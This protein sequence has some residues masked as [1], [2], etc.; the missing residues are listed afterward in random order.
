LRRFLWVACGYTVLH[1]ALVSVDLLDPVT[2]PFGP[3]WNPA[4]GLALALLLMGGIVYAP[5]VALAASL[6]AVI[7]GGE[8]PFRALADGGAMAIFCGAGALVLRMSLHLEL[9]LR[10]LRDLLL[11]FGVGVATAA[12]HAAALL[13]V[14]SAF[15]E[16]IVS[17]FLRLWAG[18]ILGIVV[19]TPFVLLHVPPERLRWPG[20]DNLVEGASILLVLWIDFGLHAAQ[21]FRFFYLLILPLVWVATRHGLKGATAAVVLAQIGLLVAVQAVPFRDPSLTLLQVIMLTLS[22]TA[23][24]LGTVVSEQRRARAALDAV[25]SMAPDGVMTIDEA[26]RVESANPACERLFRCTAPDLVGQRL[27]ALLPAVDV[28]SLPVRGEAQT[29]R[30]DGSPLLVEVAVSAASLA[31][32]RLAVAVLRDISQRKASEARL[33]EHHAHLSNA[34][35]LSVS[36]KLASALSHQLNQP[37][38]AVVGYTRAAQRLLREGREPVATIV[39]AMDQAVVQATRAGE[40]IR[41]TREFLRHGDMAPIRVAVAGLIEEAAR[42]AVPQHAARGVTLRVEVPADLPEVIADPMQVEQVLVNLLQNACD[43]VSG[44]ASANREVLVS[45]ARGEAGWV[46][47]TV[48]DNGPGIAEDIAERLFTPFTTSK[49]NGMG[50]GLFIAASIVEAHGGTM[51]VESRPGEGA[52]FSFGLPAATDDHEPAP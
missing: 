25:I 3:A 1:V 44:L 38:A 26:G 10:S 24:L 23:L 35:R 14:R 4:V 16:D 48:R 46:T 13:L 17:P 11:L 33:W 15:A 42:L 43:A 34:V 29:L 18:D 41:R 50:M 31:D 36:E 8:G 32:R 40:I 28:T 6:A 30:L 5:V 22:T 7:V 2:Y 49:A 9:R 47:V 52:A 19:I 27:S 20:L 37:L 21:K 39:E 45:A 12:L 51:R